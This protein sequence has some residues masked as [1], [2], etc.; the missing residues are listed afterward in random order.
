MGGPQNAKKTSLP[1]QSKTGELTYLNVKNF[2]IKLI[3]LSAF[4]LFL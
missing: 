4:I 2:R 1:V 3:R